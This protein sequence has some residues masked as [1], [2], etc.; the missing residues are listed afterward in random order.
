MN[1]I[2]GDDDFLTGRRTL[3]RTTGCVLTGA[4][5]SRLTS[6]PVRG[7][8]SPV[9][10]TF[11]DQVS[12]GR[13]VVVDAIETDV[14]IMFAIRDD[15][16]ELGRTYFDAGQ[17]VE[18]VTITLS[19][20]ISETQSVTAN[21]Y[22]ASGGSGL[23]RVRAE[24]TV[25]DPPER[26]EGLEP[27]LVEA[28][29]DAG[30]NYPYYLF[31]P[32]TFA[33]VEPRPPLVEP[34]NTGTAT[35]DFEQ[36]RRAGERTVSRG[37]SRGVADELFAPFVVPVFPRPRSEPVDGTHYVHQLDDTTMA[38][39][40]GPLERVDLQLLAMVEDARDRLA[41]R[42]YPVAEGIMLNGFSA[43]GNFVDRFTVLHPD[44]V[45]SVTAGG[46]NG[47]AILP[48]EEADGHTLPYHVGI[49]D[50]PE[51]TGQE[52]DLNAL[53]EVNQFLYMGAEDTN[54]TIPYT[55]A[56]TDDDLRETALAVYG[57]HMI[58][59]RFPRC[60]EAYEEAGVTAQFRVYE[61][62]G[63]TPRPA[64]E[65][66][67]EFH[68]RTLEGEDVGDI[69]ERIR[70]EL[71]VET[72]PTGPKAGESV[73]FDASGSSGGTSTLAY[74]LWEFGNGDTAVGETVEYT[75]EQAGEYTVT[76]TTV[77][78]RGTERSLREIVTISE[79]ESGDDGDTDAGTES[80]DD[81]DAGG[82]G[83]SDA[84]E[85]EGESEDS[86]DDGS[87]DDGGA[88]FGITTA[89]ASLGGAGYLLEKRLGDET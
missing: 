2:S 27:R 13:S 39:D 65:D 42:E 22:P 25:E 11:E 79:G 12:D 75:Y 35:D 44:R 5:L 54:D 61:G 29:P 59:E 72:E 8:N 41:A 9:S 6:G 1:D 83:G 37:F 45:R 67:V 51:L 80:G 38:L 21:A 58:E 60:Q 24:I 32:D 77:S 66:I 19:N 71:T 87:A 4:G 20:P 89:L 78:D 52:V 28:D 56:W 40:S 50:V 31:A 84:G 85:T 68:R 47:M 26:T 74:Y 36:H 30:F 34:T 48:L 86:S 33:D 57:D 15:S 70:P 49:A 3:L 55:D 81:P 64:R 53:D 17:R 23:A 10:I 76:L 82:E 88:G 7:Q 62:A 16:Q 69:G 46:L 73:A 18:D 14:N 43:S 63:H